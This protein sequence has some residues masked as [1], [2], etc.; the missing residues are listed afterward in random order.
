MKEHIRILTSLIAVLTI[1]GARAQQAAPVPKLVVTVVIDQLRSDYLE[2][3]SPLYYDG[4][5]NRLLK[6]GRVYADAQYPVADVDRAAATATLFTGTVP[7]DHGVVAEKWLD[8][9]TLRP[10]YC[11][12][13]LSYKGVNTDDCSSPQFLGVSTI[14]DELKV[15]TE[16]KAIVYSIAPQRD[17]AILAAGHAADGAF[18]IDDNTGRWCGSSY[19]NPGLPAWVSMCAN[20]QPLAARINKI[21]YEPCSETVGN[22]N[23]FAAGG[24]K[25]PFKHKFQGERQF[26]DFKSS[27]LVNEEVTRMAE[28]CLNSSAI[29]IDQVT[30]FLSISYSAGNFKNASVLDNPIEMQDTYVRLD[31]CIRTLLETVEKRVGL[32]NTI[33]VLTSSG[34]SENSLENLSKYKVPSGVFYINRTSALLNMYFMAQFGAGQ[35]VDAV[36]GNQIYLNHKLLEEK[37]LNIVDAMERAQEFLLQCS[38]V[39]DVYTAQ[40]L[41]LGAWTPGISQMR[42]GF[43]PKC[44]GDIFIQVAPG[45]EL[46]NEDLQTSQQIR[47][48]YVGFPI[49]FMGYDIEAKTEYAPTSVDVIAPT[50]AHYMR[51]RAPN[52]CSTRPLNDL[53]R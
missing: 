35:Y 47:V 19:Y 9:T 17:A 16:G 25:T 11:V 38:G 46:R 49:I 18:W 3:F 15:A 39:K 27:A 36:F 10:V 51:I 7:Y 26:V 32:K 1:T 30:D 21:V 52:A 8:R 23:Y 44:S 37:Q 34:S 20:S 22:F 4:G 48:S 45:W 42:N 6:E 2:A 40:R 13:D 43:N 29:G 12:D 41:T 33:F 50:L 5:L 31:A 53:R 28:A 24:M 14:G